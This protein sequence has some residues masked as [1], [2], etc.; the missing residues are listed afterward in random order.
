MSHYTSR[1]PSSTS[2]RM[3][4]NPPAPASHG[5]GRTSLRERN[6]MVAKAANKELR[7]A[8]FEPMNIMKSDAP[9]AETFCCTYDFQ[10]EI[11]ELPIVKDPKLLKMDSLY[12][13]KGLKR[14][15]T[16]WRLSSLESEA[17]GMLLEQDV[18][19][20]VDLLDFDSEA[21]AGTA[22]I[23][24]EDKVLLYD[25]QSKKKKHMAEKKMVNSNVFLRKPVYVTNDLYTTRDKYVIGHHSAEKRMNREG[26]DEGTRDE[27]VDRIQATFEHVDSFIKHPT[28]P[29][30]RPKRVMPILPDVNSAQS[31]FIQVKFDQDPTPEGVETEESAAVLCK[32]ATEVQDAPPNFS[33]FGYFNRIENNGFGESIGE[34]A[35]D[36]CSYQFVRPY[37]WD[38]KGY[39]NHLDKGTKFDFKD[40]FLVLEFPEDDCE[41]PRDENGKIIQDSKNAVRFSNVSARMAMTKARSKS[42]RLDIK[43]AV[44]DV[45]RLV[46]D[47]IEPRKKEARRMEQRL[48]P[49]VDPAMENISDNEDISDDE[50][51]SEDAPAAPRP[52]SSGTKPTEQQST[53]Q[54]TEEQIDDDDDDFLI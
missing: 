7:K 6:R 44:E 21:A 46:V 17:S 36:R 26:N 34:H 20:S 39:L 27:V 43:E 23:V 41:Q 45:D 13:A 1:P 9:F 4:H 22:K 19:L 2:S 40:R 47:I 51:E 30:M 14:K 48:R 25:G 5:S 35:G 52:S 11:P 31:S 42:L 24:E 29:K 33:A 38:N 50:S 28:N 8:V 37:L 16:E 53:A 15:F 54:P 10:T 3:S 18:G 49:L 12:S 32:V